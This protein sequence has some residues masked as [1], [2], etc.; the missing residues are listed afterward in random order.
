[1]YTLDKSGFKKDFH[2]CDFFYGQMVPMVGNKSGLSRSEG[3]KAEGKT[4]IPDDQTWSE[5]NR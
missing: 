1:M 2:G 5:A 3:F 4:K